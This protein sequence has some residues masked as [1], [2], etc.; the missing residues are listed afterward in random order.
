MDTNM[1][2]CVRVDFHDHMPSYSEPIKTAIAEPKATSIP[3][4]CRVSPVQMN[5][6]PWPPGDTPVVPESGIRDG[7]LP[8]IPMA[9]LHRSSTRNATGWPPSP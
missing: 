2:S 3:V 5:H 4:P 7:V 1:W 8:S 9:S 6:E